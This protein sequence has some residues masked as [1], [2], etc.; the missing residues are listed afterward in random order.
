MNHGAL[1]HGKG[2]QNP[3]LDVRAPGFGV[4]FPCR[5][6]KHG[7]WKYPGFGLLIRG[8]RLL[9]LPKPLSPKSEALNPNRGLSQSP[10]GLS[11]SQMRRANPDQR[12][13]ARPCTIERHMHL[14]RPQGSQAT[15]NRVESVAKASRFEFLRGSKLRHADTK[16]TQTPE[17]RKPRNPKNP[18][19]YTL[20]RRNPNLQPNFH[21]AELRVM[22]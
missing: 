3:R 1:L 14:C 16:D 12:R 13:R 19:L 15:L 22:V 21:V 17:T 9:G 18:K 8:Q 20:N 2:C 4:S 6:L 5:S 11:T 10:Y 7:A